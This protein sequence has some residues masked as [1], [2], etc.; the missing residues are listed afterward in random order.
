MLK[1]VKCFLILASLL[2]LEGCA[3]ITTGTNQSLSV[4]TEPEKGATCQLSNDKGTWYINNT[5]GSVTVNRAYSD[6][7]I[8][9]K[10]GEKSNVIK[11]KSSTKAMTAGNIVVGGI[12]GFAVD[13]GTGSAYDYPSV[14]TIPLQ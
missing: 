11:V 5:P 3:S 1:Y 2:S 13:A 6:M 12:I 7:T 9:C 14:I 4:N 8:L 10:K